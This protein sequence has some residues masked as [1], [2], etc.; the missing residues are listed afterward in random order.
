MHWNPLSIFPTN[1]IG[2]IFTIEKYITPAV[3]I[4]NPPHNN[5]DSPES[6]QTN[7]DNEQNIS[8][9]KTNLLT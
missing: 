5:K 4:K 2:G 6:E 8:I 7:G 3:N 9:Q 1:N